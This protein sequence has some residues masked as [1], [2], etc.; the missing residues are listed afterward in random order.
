MDP[1]PIIDNVCIP[2]TQS[3]SKLYGSQFLQDF[4]KLEYKYNKFCNP[5]VMGGDPMP[6]IGVVYVEKT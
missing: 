6:R 3:V 5:S 4:I 1:L 2:L